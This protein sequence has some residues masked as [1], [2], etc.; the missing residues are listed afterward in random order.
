MTQYDPMQ[1]VKVRNISDEALERLRRSADRNGRSLESEIRYRLEDLAEAGIDDFPMTLDWQHAGFDDVAEIIPGRQYMVYADLRPF[2][3]TVFRYLTDAN[4]KWNTEIETSEEV[5]G[6][7]CWVRV[8]NVA[9]RHYGSTARMALRDCIRWLAQHAGVDAISRARE[10]A[11]HFADLPSQ[12]RTIIEQL[13]SIIDA[14]H[15]MGKRDVAIWRTKHHE[16][17]VNMVD[18]KRGALMVY[19]VGESWSVTNG[20]P[21]YFPL[22]KSAPSAIR[23]ELSRL[24][25]II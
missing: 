23:E 20:K 17:Y 25:V 11:E 6:Q 22:T 3:V 13:D 21:Y 18:G 7:T 14:G 8:L 5:G 19:P 4:P 24:S 1:D 9:D 15:E 16:I 10:S 12:F 2:K